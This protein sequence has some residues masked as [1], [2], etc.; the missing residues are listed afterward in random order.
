MDASDDELTYDLTRIDIGSD[1]H[2]LSLLS[3]WVTLF[4]ATLRYHRHLLHRLVGGA[5]RLFLPFLAWT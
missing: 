5:L 2:S 1:G 3:P 4:G